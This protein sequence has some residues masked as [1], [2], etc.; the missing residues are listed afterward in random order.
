MR[1]EPK[2]VFILEDGT[3]KEL[4]YQG[5]SDQCELADPSSKRY[6][7][8]LHGMLMEVSKE[9]YKDFY[10]ARRRQEYLRECS[11]ENGEI[12]YDL[13]TTEDL[14]GEDILVDESQNVGE[15]AVN[16]IILDKLSE[17]IHCLS[18]DE[19]EVIYALF[20][21]EL[22]ER[23]YADRKGV[24]R[25]AVHKKKVWILTKLKKFMGF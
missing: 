6:F 19:L 12:S 13:L 21:E 24:Y 25:N 20:Y 9:T 1:H 8:S 14:K 11:I 15:E 18:D 17:A 5:F 7:L 10:G 4:F 2:K 23:E 16:R 3:Y 22:T